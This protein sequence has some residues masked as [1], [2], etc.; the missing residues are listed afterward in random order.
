MTTTNASYLAAAERTPF[1]TDWIIALLPTVVGLRGLNFKFAILLLAGLTAFAIVRKS[2]YRFRLAPGPLILIFLST[3]IV[4]SRPLD[5]ATLSTT[6]FSIA[7]VILAGTLALLLATKVD[8]RTIVASLINGCGLY[9][10]ASVTI[11]AMGYRG[12]SSAA[13]IGGLVESTG[14]VRVLYPLAVT[15]NSTPAIAALFVTTLP[16]IFRESTRR[17]RALQAAFFISALV[18]LV[19]AGS[20]S[21]I[22]IATFVTTIVMFFPGATRWLAQATTIVAVFSVLVIPPILNARFFSVDLI[23]IFNP[24]RALDQASVGSLQGRDRIWSRSIQYWDTW[25]NDT[26]RLFGFGSNGHYRSGASATYAEQLAHLSKHPKGAGMHNSYLQQLFDGGLIGVALLA[27][28]IYWASVRLAKRNQVLGAAGT[29]AVAAM[30]VL[31]IGSITEVSLAPGPALESFWI[32]MILVGVSCQVVEARDP[33]E[34]T[35]QVEAPPRTLGSVDALA[36][37]ADRGSDIASAVSAST[38]GASS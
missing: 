25:T 24:R 4:V 22:M 31:I 11:Y 8:A 28:A 37:N 20:V 2:E 27:L 10:L 5:S 29:G 6:I 21:A 14:F 34:P 1:R 7:T 9:S 15:I 30:T 36:P 35:K 3:A 13:R 32:L 17:M 18:I 12:A 19:T 23:R 16:F 33:G 26:Q 38:R